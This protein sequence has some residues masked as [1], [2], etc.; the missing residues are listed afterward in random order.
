MKKSAINP[1]PVI[2]FDL[3]QLEIFR[4]VVELRSFSKAAA[5]V[6]LAQASVSERIA[7]LEGMVGTRLLDRLGRQVVP[8]RAGELLYTHAVRLLEM[9][10][11]ACQEMQDFLGVKRGEIRIGGSTIPG[12][13]ILPRV[14][15]RFRENYPHVS[16]TLTVGST[17]DIEALV[18]DGDLELGVIGSM[19]ASRHLMSEEIWKDELVLAVPVRHRWAKKGETSIRE[20]CREPFILRAG[21]SGTL[22][23]M[24][25]YLHALESKGSES[26]NVVARFGTSSSVKEGIKAG[27][28]VSI[29]SSRALE[30]E[31]KAG[32]LRAVKVRGL[33]MFRS[34]YLIRDTRKIA[35]PLCRAMLDFLLSTA[36]NQ[37]TALK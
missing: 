16:V 1:T 9:K 29:L 8:T 37:A 34:F 15:G 7:N 6:F 30:T 31:L 13:Y 21:G 24:E 14:I 33:S 11:A 4:K 10:E 36:E 27:L 19:S 3:R 28:G 32:I 20:L 17:K 35:S 5:A 25:D 26:L 23:I 18:L 12:E 22:K 2:D